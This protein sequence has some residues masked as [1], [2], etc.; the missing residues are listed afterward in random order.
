MQ[1]LTAGL[2]Y[3]HPLTAGITLDAHADASYRSNVTTQINASAAGYQQLGGYT[4]VDASAGLLFGR[5]LRARL[6]ANNLTN[7]AGISAAGAVLKN[8]NFY[9]EYREE[10]LMRPRTVGVLVEYTFE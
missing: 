2:G 6:Y 10:Y 1:T 3:T 4:T 8:A 5:H 9:P 7:Q